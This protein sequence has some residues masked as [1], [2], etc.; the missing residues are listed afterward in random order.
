[1]ALAAGDDL[2][3]LGD[4]VGDELLDLLDRLLVDQRALLHAVL[5]AGADLQLAGGRGKL[6]DELVVDAG[7]HEEAVGADAGLAGI[8]VLGG[9]RAFDRAVDVGVVEDDERRIAA[10]FHRHLLDRRRPTSAISILPTSVEPVKVIFLT[11][12]LAQIS[13]PISPAEPVRM[14]TT[15]LG[16]PTSSHSAPQA[17]PE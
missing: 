15:P 17:R 10:E 5:E 2:A 3:A 7:L 16:K 11:S 13:S 4:G 12:G 1:M 9:D 6:L 8:A 14:L